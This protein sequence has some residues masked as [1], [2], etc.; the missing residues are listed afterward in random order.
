VDD[1]FF[2]TRGGIR[3][4]DIIDTRTQIMAMGLGGYTFAN[5]HHTHNDNLSIIDKGTLKAVGQTLMQVIYN[6]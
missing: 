2:V 4:V 3:C 1:H 5:Y 6:Q